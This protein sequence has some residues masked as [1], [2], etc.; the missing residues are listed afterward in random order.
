[1]A[2][3]APSGR[4][5]GDHYRLVEPLDVGGMGRVWRA[6]DEALHIDV[7]IK[8]V[9]LSP[10]MPAG[11]REE[12]LARAK[13]EARNAA[14]LRDHP[15]IVAV[16]DVVTEDGVPWIVMRLVTGESLE[17]RL[18]RGPL[19]AAE[20]T[21]VAGDLLS[22]LEAAHAAGIVHRDVKPA[23][24]L[25]ADNGNTL[26]ADFGIAVHH[27]D[28]SITTTGSLI[29]SVE[30]MAPE[31]LNGKD[32]LPESDLYS[33]GV[34]LFQAVEGLSPFRRDT[35]TATLTAVLLEDTPPLTRGGNLAALI[36]RL[37]DKNP[38]ARPKIPEARALLEAPP[39]PTAKFEPTPPKPTARIELSPTPPGGGYV[40][41]TPPG[42]S[43]VAPPPPARPAGKLPPQAVTVLAVVFGLLIGGLQYVPGLIGTVR[44]LNGLGPT[45]SSGWPITTTTDPTTR[46]WSTTTSDYYPTTTTTTTTTP[47][48]DPTSL[49]RESTDQTPLTTGALLADT[50][51][52]EKGVEHKLEGAD[53]RQCIT[54]YMSQEVR[55]LLTNT[56]C[57][58]SV[59][60]T[61]VDRSG[62]I[63]TMLWVVPMPDATTAQTTYDATGSGSWGVLCPQTGP[64]AEICDNNLD[65]TK[66][67]QSGYTRRTHR[68]L[69]TSKS[70]YINLTTDDTATPWLDAAADQA[71]TSAG[72]EN[73][74]GNR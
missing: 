25:L 20:A 11:E 73:H 13:R 31:R 30:Y 67:R 9:W 53:V 63:M 74:P 45:D 72:P 4:V 59:T 1:M 56:G 42:G 43:Y 58:N 64:G 21:R 62:Q 24:V 26:L 52:D 22:A 36:T 69:I 2:D 37:L 12:R 7:A 28:T 38:D 5:V 35:P 10:A 23:N 29:G 49:D 6:R 41:P 18:A 39:S 32:G 3:V 70:L 17:K 68:Y 55:D 27:A 15:N 65:V 33:L 16:H 19:T 71:V 51:V 8:E 60:A 50:F 14:V 48:F 47:S 44:S 46:D 57:R 34:T 61:Y 66:A 54:E 40:A